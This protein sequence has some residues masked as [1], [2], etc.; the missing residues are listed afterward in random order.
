MIDVNE[1]FLD[2]MN[3]KKHA[4]MAWKDYQSKGR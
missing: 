4:A 2:L 1:Y 3:I